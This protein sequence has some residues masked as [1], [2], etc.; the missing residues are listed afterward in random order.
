M[1]RIK[2]LLAEVNDI[3][4]LKVEDA[5][6]L[7]HLGYLIKKETII[8]KLKMLIQVIDNPVYED[9]IREAISFIEEGE[10]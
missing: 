7:A 9:V 1:S 6:E 10:V 4:D 5:M 2:D 3:D 8:N